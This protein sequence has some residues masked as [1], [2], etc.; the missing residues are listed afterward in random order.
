M[1]TTDIGKKIVKIREARGL[2]QKELAEQIPVS[3]ST[4]SRWEKGIVIPPLQQL[5]R[6]CEVLDVPFSQLFSDSREDY[7]TLRNNYFRLKVTMGSLTILFLVTIMFICMPKY[8]IMR[9]GE[10][11]D[12]YYGQTL[13]IYVKPL[14]SFSDAGAEAFVKKVAKNYSGRE[15]LVGI[16]IVFV[17]DKKD[18]LNDENEHL[19]YYCFLRE[20]PD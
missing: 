5:E 12:G 19:S 8:R 2:S 15:D 7:D 6:T 16:E 11:Y 1:K 18:L 10:V 20:M 13:T 14:F 9:E 17:R 4:L 3:P